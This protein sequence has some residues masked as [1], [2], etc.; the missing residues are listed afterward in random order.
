[1]QEFEKL[2]AF[3]LGKKRDDATGKPTEEVVLYDSGDLTTHAVIIGMTGSGK[4]GLGIGLIEEA[5]LDH[6]PV[7]A[8]DPKGDLGNL[9]LSFPGLK[10]ADF[11]PW[12]DARAASAAGQTVED[13]AASTAKTWKKG[14]ADWGQG[15]DRIESLRKAA[16]FSIYTP[17]SSA[18]LPLAVLGQFSPPAA[19]LREDV[20][21]MN[22]RIAST[23]DGL[24]ALLGVEA[25]PVTSPE[26]ILLSNILQRRW[27][28]GASL[29]LAEL[30]GAI[31]DP[32]FD[33]LGVMDLET[34]Y[35]AKQRFGLAMRLNG[36]LAAPGFEVWM[37]GDLLEPSKLFYSANGKPRV[38]VISIAHLNDAQRMFF[39]TLLLSEIIA[40]MRLQPG[41]S[42]LRAVLYMDEIFGY[43]P[44]V[45][46]PPSKQ[47]F[48]TL[49]KQA[50]AYGLGLVLST[51][52]P[53][54]LDYKALSNAGTWFIGR[55]QTDRDKQRL[56]EGLETAAGSGVFGRGELDA[57]LSGL[58]K[59]QF[60]LHN[61][62]EQSP[63]VFVTRWVMSYL[64]GPMTREQIKRLAADL[65]PA[66]AGEA[67]ESSP[68]K[69]ESARQKPMD[70]AA[71][72]TVAP[73]V[74]PPEIRQCY[75]P[76]DESAADGA[77]TLYRPALVAIASLYYSNATLNLERSSEIV[78]ALELDSGDLTADWDAADELPL[79]PD[80]LAAEPDAGASYLA[81][82]SALA[83]PKNLVAWERSLKR[84][85]RGAR[86]LKLWRSDRFKLY[87][88]PEESEAEFRIRLQ[89]S[90]NEM[91][92]QKV[93]QLK[94]KYETKVARIED[95]LMRARQALEREAEQ[96]RGAKVDTALSIGTAVLGALLG[97]KR[98][99]TTSMNRAG[100]AVRKAGSARKQ[101]GDVK[102][103]KE[104]IASLEQQLG[105]LATD[106]DAEVDEL[107]DSFDAQD[108]LLKDKIV[109]P[110]STD[111][112]IKFFGIGWIPINR[113]IDGF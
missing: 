66:V 74:L 26:H 79:N 49:L 21:L 85:L 56:R 17:G 18:G 28:D 102:R 95:R 35:P 29:S 57:I 31:Q 32:G 106:F 15:S 4:T 46:N 1:M 7:I 78:L 105:D 84:W 100:S 112:E 88:K 19:T 27:T 104:T 48:L 86:P 22:E 38:S 72:A 14:L 90:A 3:Y 64:A 70:S 45:A 113:S 108:E 97:R 87:S 80:D 67:A 13:F 82:V 98:I 110:K 37:E 36:L 69:L 61:V 76:A 77:E 103:A 63:V 44:P 47:L 50:R 41:S 16:D 81:P 39:V 111:I 20:D 43:L 10:P 68:P 93:A 25:D 65:V 34:F 75:L 96:A 40:W 52:N 51:Q 12:V 60:L 30:I 54:D 94:A 11:E 8:V 55:L 2:G 92:D 91:R 99:S 107:D 71:G 73:P 5:A 23:V 6:V 24:L 101:S 83:N 58:G 62:H 42:S 89:H 9:L 59:R 109:R 53:V 33:K